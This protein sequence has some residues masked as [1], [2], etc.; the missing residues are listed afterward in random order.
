M[1]V[2]VKLDQLGPNGEGSYYCEKRLEVGLN[3]ASLHDA[4][5]VAVQGDMLGLCVTKKSWD[6][7]R[8]IDVHIINDLHGYAYVYHIRALALEYEK[9]DLQ[10]TNVQTQLSVLCTHFKRILHDC[11]KQVT[12]P[13]IE[14]GSARPNWVC[15]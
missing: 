4:L 15:L 1:V 7:D 6:T 10:D 5:N 9:I 11:Q 14:R 12:M 8:T 2:Y 3:F 13:T